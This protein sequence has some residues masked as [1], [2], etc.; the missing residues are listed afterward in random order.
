MASEAQPGETVAP[1]MEHTALFDWR[2]NL[3][4]TQA[5]KTAISIPDPLFKAAEGLARR[6]GIT[7]SELYQKAVAAFVEKHEARVVTNALDELYGRNPDVATL[8]RGVEALQTLSLP[9]DDW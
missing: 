5:V 8:D 7:R 6:L 2:Y 4:Y 9:K 3:S 1:T